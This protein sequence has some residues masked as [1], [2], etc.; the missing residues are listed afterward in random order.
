MTLQNGLVHGGR[1][2][3]W[4]DT[5]FYDAFTG[6]LLG[7]DSKAMQG[8][9]W[10]WAGVLSSIGGDPHE[11]ARMVGEAWPADVPSVLRA[12]AAALRSYASHGHT[13]RVLLATWQDRPQLWMVATDDAGGDGPFVPTEA[14][15]Y[16]NFG[17]TLPAYKRAAA[18]GFNPKRMHRVIDAQIAEPFELAGTFA[19]TGRRH[20]LGGNVV[21]IEVS[22]EG[23]ESRVLRPVSVGAGAAEFSEPK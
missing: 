1:A 9:Y 15:H 4:T 6:E 22:G 20:W 10:P 5:A 16:L 8:L 17:N 13:A 3:L 19:A 7:F 21:E 12:T 23:V 18:K 14:T 2:Y 11:I